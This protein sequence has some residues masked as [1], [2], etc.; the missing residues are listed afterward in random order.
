MKIRFYLFMMALC[1]L[2]VTAQKAQ[3]Y[4]NTAVQMPQVVSE[5]PV[6]RAFI[7]NELAGVAK[8]VKVDGQTLYFLTVSS[9]ASGCDVR[10]ETEDGTPL[11]TRQSINYAPDAH[12][13]SL[14]AP[15][16]LRPGDDRPYK[17]IENDR[18]IIIRDNEKYGIDGMKLK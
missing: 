7:G 8:P 3:A 10:F 13:G 6:I 5:T 18:V 11:S 15:V 16:I 12:H 4:G 9:N 1:G 2:L 17:I 14:K